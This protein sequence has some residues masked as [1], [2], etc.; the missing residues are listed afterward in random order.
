M[1]ICVLFGSFNPL[2]NAHISMLKEAVEALNADRG[3]FVPTNGQYLKRK[4]VK[5]NDAFYLSEDERR[6]I[7]ERA[8]EGED[9][10]SFAMFE[11]GGINPR[12]FKTL[13]KIQKQY[14]AAEIFEVMGADKVHTLYKSAHADDYL[15][16][17]KI[18]VF[19][20]RDIDLEQMFTEHSVLSAHRSSFV[21]LPALSE[22]SGI[23][24]TEVRRRF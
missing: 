24:S 17:F 8:C 16:Q 21:M 19:Q 11:L 2:T 7:I 9:K 23:S 12:R 13:C 4:I 14:P 10:L 1:K 22:G 5:I 20:R 6:A 15:T 18:S 3:Y